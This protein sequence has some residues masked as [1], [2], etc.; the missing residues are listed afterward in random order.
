MTRICIAHDVSDEAVARVE[1]LLDETALR[2]PDWNGAEFCIVRNDFTAIDDSN[3]I[4][5]AILLS[6]V[7]RAIQENMQ[8]NTP[9]T[10]KQRE[11]QLI[12]LLECCQ[13]ELVVMHKE[14]AKQLA[15]LQEV[16]E[17]VSEETLAAADDEHATLSVACNALDLCIRALNQAAQGA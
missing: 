6:A 11:L 14:C 10:R 13:R 1:A 15:G 17:H 5:A 2:D 8:T 7:H 12:E 3:G 4:R 16:P 9:P